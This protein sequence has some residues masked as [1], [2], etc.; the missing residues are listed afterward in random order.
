VTSLPIS[1]KNVPSSSPT[2]PADH[3]QSFRDLGERECAHVVERLRLS[4]SFD[5][6]H[7]DLRS[8][9]DD[10]RLCVNG[11]IA[12]PE[13]RGRDKSPL[14]FDEIGLP[15]FQERLDA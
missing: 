4:Q 11:L 2:A 12:D 7:P 15:P 3:D 10:Q 9:R 14:T 13:L 8:G 1:A 6:R 5:R